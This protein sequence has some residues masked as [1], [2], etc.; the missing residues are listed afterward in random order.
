MNVGHAL[1]EENVKGNNFKPVSPLLHTPNH[2][3]TLNTNF[4]MKNVS[5]FILQDLTPTD[6]LRNYNTYLPHFCNTSMETAKR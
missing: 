6:T 4:H 1:T 2:K 5:K 3:A